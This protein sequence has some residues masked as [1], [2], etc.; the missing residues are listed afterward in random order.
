MKEGKKYALCAE[1]I[2]VMISLSIY[3]FIYICVSVHINIP[4]SVS[5]F[6]S[7]NYLLLVALIL[8]KLVGQEHLGLTDSLSCEV[9]SK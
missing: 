7:F 8:C 3:V 6:Q 4:M 9:N 1:G 2:C 5:L